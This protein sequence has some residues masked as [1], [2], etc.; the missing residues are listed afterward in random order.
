MRLATAEKLKGL[1]EAYWSKRE[2]EGTWKRPKTF[3]E[4]SDV[5]DGQGEHGGVTSPKNERDKRG[6][7][8]HKA[9]SKSRKGESR[10]PGI[11]KKSQGGAEFKPKFDYRNLKNR[12][13]QDDKELDDSGKHDLRKRKSDKR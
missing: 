1:E 13:N 9:S 6:S 2:A 4:N 10:T 11:L 8:D 5:A 7:R 12:Q 3:G